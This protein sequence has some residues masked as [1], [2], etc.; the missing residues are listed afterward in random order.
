MKDSDR[1]TNQSA[2]LALPRQFRWIVVGLAVWLVLSVLGFFRAGH[3]GLMLA[4]VS[5]FIGVAVMLPLILAH[6]SRRDDRNRSADEAETL[7]GW[8]DREFDGYTGRMKAS[9]AAFQ[10]LLPLAAVALGMTFFALS[11]IST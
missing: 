2:S 4:I 11:A 10:V 5:F 8:L 3:T 6:I 9:A 7:R 1:R